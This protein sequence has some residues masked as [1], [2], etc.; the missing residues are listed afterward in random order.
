MSIYLKREFPVHLFI[1]ST[2]NI[3]EVQG[4][5][6]RPIK[7]CFKKW[8]ISLFQVMTELSK[9][10]VSLPLW[11]WGLIGGAALIS[12]FRYI[13]APPNE[14]TGPFAYPIIGN[15]VQL[16]D[17]TRLAHFQHEISLKYGKVSRLVMPGS[18]GFVVTDV[19]IVKKLL[20]TDF[21]AWG[22]GGISMKL[23]GDIAGGLILQD[24]NNEW[25][26]TRKLFDPFF[27]MPA[28][29]SYQ[30]IVQ[31]RM[32]KFL[33]WLEEQAKLPENNRKGP[34]I[35][36]QNV[37]HGITFDIIVMITMGSDPDSVPS[38]GHS[39][40][41]HAWEYCLRHLMERI[42]YAIT[43]YWTW[44]KTPAVKKYERDYKTLSSIVTDRRKYY[45]AHPEECNQAVDMM[46]Q[47]VTKMKNDPDALPGYLLTEEKEFVR[48]FVTMIF[49]GHDTTASASA[50]ALGYLCESSERKQKLA[51]E[52]EQLGDAKLPTYEAL[53]QLPYLTA[54][55]K[56]TLRL[57]PSAPSIARKLARD[58]T[59]EWTDKNGAVHRQFLPKGTESGYQPYCVM[60]SP[61]NYDT[62]ETFDPERW[63]DDRA[64]NY[65]LYAY[66]PFGGGPR[67]CL[68]EKLALYEI[69]MI[70]VTV[71]RNFDIQLVE[72]HVLDFITAPTMRMKYGLKVCVKHR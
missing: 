51:A 53:D 36:L 68:G 10:T 34:G 37:L 65:A 50:W 27:A 4:H 21:T 52:L 42:P 30:P 48:H 15:L 9:Y 26:E 18:I 55:V 69:K 72:G 58:M 67:R 5:T 43:S 14:A 39:A 11:G 45:E 61:D 12:A 8:K 71:L 16:G 23:F 13:F 49:A 3:R 64:K 40:Q 17:P 66:I 24:N 1:L 6:A 70:I 32:E 46:A 47:F 28:I 20:Q 57:R 25:K 7:N 31:G 41:L 62:P 38:G 63:L 29:K 19:A 56:E 2:L 33:T 59:Y 54:V 35:D 44:W 60:H 22:R